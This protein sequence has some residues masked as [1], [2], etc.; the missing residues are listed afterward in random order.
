MP[1]G[2][3]HG[4]TPS[5]RAWW[6]FV[7]PPPDATPFDFSG[8][9]RFL[10]I[11]TDG[12]R[13]VYQSRGP[14]GGPQLTLRPIDQ[15]VG[16][17][18]RGGEGGVSPFVSP[19][20]EWVGF[21]SAGNATLQKVSILGGPPVTLAE[22]PSIIVGASWGTDDQIIVGT[23]SGGLFRVPGGGGKPEILTSPDADEGERNHRWPS[24][25][26]GRQAVLF[27]IG[28][29]RGAAARQLAVLALDSGKVTRL[30][31][32]GTSPQ[33]AS[34]G[35]LVYAVE[36]G[37]VRAVPFDVERLEV[38]GNPVP[39]LEGVVV[40]NTSGAANFSIAAN[41]RLVYASGAGLPG[42]R[43]LVW[44]DREGREEPL[45]AEPGP[46]T[47]PRVSPDGTRVAVDRQDSNWDVWVYSVARRTLTRVTT[48]PADDNH[49]LWTLD[50]ERLVF[51]S[52]RE[53]ARGLFWKA[54]DGTGTTERLMES[55]SP[56]FIGPGGW[57]PEGNSLIFGEIPLSAANYDIGVLSME[58]DRQSE[59]LLQM[60]F[61]EKA[62]T[63]SPDGRWLAYFT[64]ETGQDEVYVQRFPDLGEKQQIS[65]G[66]GREPLWSPDGREL[67]YRGQ[68]GLM[69]V[70]ILDTEPTFRVG[71][72]EI[73]FE[74][75]YASYLDRRNYD[76]SP[77]GRRFLMIKG[78]ATDAAA[79][80]TQIVVVLNWFEELKERVPIP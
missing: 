79:P 67:F 70:T 68:R 28:A 75:A 36:D 41:G 5:R 62:P 64:N 33:Y 76:V 57:S 56:I 35:H 23:L 6:R 47:T 73:V 7:I 66:G 45:A 78:A 43:S 55:A 34:T 29:G 9:F 58:G 13:I 74:Q 38:T 1:F 16:A 21:V 22:L 51:Q 42:E 32:A 25:I 37:S 15:L 52:I 18:L 48:D 80:A 72:A 59:P 10:V 77:D 60:G 49:P 4:Q 69:A 8:N 50:G 71:S 3:S 24:V 30:G 20:G 19:D 65:V 53:D 61:A 54:A 27:A 31:L 46:Y 44:V 40:N 39:I 14:G 12:T 2:G 63:V 11:S 17:P 26:P